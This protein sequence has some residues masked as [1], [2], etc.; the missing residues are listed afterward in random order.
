MRMM[1]EV[2]YKDSTNMFVSYEG[3]KSNKKSIKN[4]FDQINETLNSYYNYLNKTKEQAIISG[5]VSDALST[6]MNYVLKTKGV[7][8]NLSSQ[9]SKM[10]NSFLNEI[11]TEDDFLYGKKEEKDFSDYAYEKF[12]E[13]TIHRKET[14]NWFKDHWNDAGR[15]F[16][17]DVLGIS[18]IDDYDANMYLTEKSMK[19]L[20]K[21]ESRR[22]DDIFKM[23]RQTDRSYYYNCVK[24]IDVLM[25]FRGILANMIEI[26]ESKKSFS[27]ENIETKLGPLYNSL[28]ES[29]EKSVSIYDTSDDAI[30]SFVQQRWAASYFSSFH[31][32]INQYLSDIGGIEIVNA[33]I[34]NSFGIVLDDIKYGDYEQFLI[35]NQL[36]DTLQEMNDSYDYSISR[37][38]EV[39]DSLKDFV[40]MVKDKGMTVTEWL[41]Q[42]RDSSGKLLL[43]KRTKKYKRIAEFLDSFKNAGEILKYGDKGIDFISRLLTDYDKALEIIESFAKNANMDEKVKAAIEEIERLYK[44]DLSAW[45]NDIGEKVADELVEVGVSALAKAI[46]VVNVIDTIRGGIDSFGEITGSGDRAKS[47]L[48]A[49]SY[50]NIYYSSQ[51]A[52]E[53]ALRK[54]K[55]AN[56]DDNN[57]DQLLQD[58]KNCFSFCK[59]NLVKMLTEMANSVQGSKKAYY[60]YCASVASQAKLIDADKL[61]V[62]SYEDYM[63]GIY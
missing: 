46:P 18:F 54:L 27:V 59:K 21:T 61:T 11:D 49:L 34:Y 48:N 12:Q 14:G 23:V 55:E 47:M 58:F 8:L 5:E 19:E 44:K 63:N 31:T 26:L 51:N 9:Y 25:G 24:Y 60:Q 42:H 28:L 16:V 50:Q 37:E 15:W 43:D 56:V 17:Q 32:A 35:K 20:A 40:K 41:N 4:C 1:Y 10:V 52:Y 45:L 53:E 30:R 57:Y 36:L 22:I 33:T 38:K 7:A 62:P 3:Y 13:V 6:Y 2:P 29:I 39:V